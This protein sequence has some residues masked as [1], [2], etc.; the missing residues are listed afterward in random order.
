MPA[1][2][3]QRFLATGPAHLDPSDV[4]WAAPARTRLVRRA[5]AVMVAVDDPDPDAEI[6]P[7]RST[8]MIQHH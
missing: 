5:F 7:H 1:V 2:P 8:T 6:I 4:A 3:L